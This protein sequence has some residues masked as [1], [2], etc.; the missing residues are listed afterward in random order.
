MYLL[1]KVLETPGI[2]SLLLFPAEV[3]QHSVLLASTIFAPKSV[4]ENIFK[5]VHLK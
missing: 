3:R 2:F 4:F 1:M 5:T